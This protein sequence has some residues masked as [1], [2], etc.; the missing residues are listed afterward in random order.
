[1]DAG[2]SVAEVGLCGSVMGLGPPTTNTV[3][4]GRNLLG[5]NC[6]SVGW[7]SSSLVVVSYVVFIGF[8]VDG[9]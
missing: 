2:C 6:I 8:S 3:T 4:I 7:V 1:M 5:W 9:T